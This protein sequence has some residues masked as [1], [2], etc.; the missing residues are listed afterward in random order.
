MAGMSDRSETPRARARADM[1]E[2]IKAVARDHLAAEGPNLSL[3]AVARDL[4]VVSSA[5]YRYFASRDELLTA[6]I[7][8]GYTSA[9]DAVETAEAAVPRRD[10]AG[11]WLALGRG[12]RRWALG[13]P[14]EFAL[15]YGSPV[16]GY[17]AP[18]ETVAQAAR[19]VVVAAGILRD[20][21]ARGVLEI[22]ADRLPRAVRADV[23]TLVRSP[24]FEDV[25]VTLMARAMT[26]WAQLYGTISFE[27][28]GRYVNVV[29]DLDAYFEHQLRVMSR[30]LGLS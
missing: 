6:L 11:R 21:V 12:T 27:L 2:R 20:G 28:F 23:E 25:P 14:H 7:L 22:P 17:Q 8:D 9:A 19:P 26:V 1:V 10:L 30:Y 16:P 5:V 24:G 15:L 29:N 3:R 13:K 18:Q 4:G